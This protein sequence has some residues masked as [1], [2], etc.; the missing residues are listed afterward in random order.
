MAARHFVTG[1]QTAFDGDKD[2]HH[3]LYAGLQ[4]VALGQFFL[5]DLIQLIRFF[6]FLLQA[7]FNQFQLLGQIFIGQTDIKPIVPARQTRQ[8]FGRDFA[9][10]GQLHRTAVGF[11]TDNHTLDTVECVVVENTQLVVQIQTVA[12]QFGI[13]N[14]LGAFVALD[15]FAGKDLNVDNRTAHTGRHTQ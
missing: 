13:D 14:G 9:A 15:A 1:L 12:F 7:Q 4:L 6:A 11:L 3:F 10:F 5:L 2:F 8:I